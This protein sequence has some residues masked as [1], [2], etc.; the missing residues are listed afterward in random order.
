[1]LEPYGIRELAQSG[2]LAMGRGPKSITERIPR[3]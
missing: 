3:P 1:V 2:L